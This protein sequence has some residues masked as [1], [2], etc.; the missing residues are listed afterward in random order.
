[1]AMETHL[2][3]IAALDVAGR[4]NYLLEMAH[5][6][7]DTA[8]EAMIEG[9]QQYAMLSRTMAEAIFNSADELARDNTA[10]AA[11]MAEKATI[12][13]SNFHTAYPYR[14]VSYALN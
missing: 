3:T 8:R 7:E 11:K 4:E 14:I 5:S 13:I 9:N 12:I 2:D 6:L 1:M 10:T